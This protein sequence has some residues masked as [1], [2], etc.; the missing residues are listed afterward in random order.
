MAHRSARCAVFPGVLG[1]A[2]TLRDLPQHGH[3]TGHRL[4]HASPSPMP[5][6]SDDVY[7]ERIQRPVARSPLGQHERMDQE[8]GR[9]VEERCIA[10]MSQSEFVLAIQASVGS[11]V[12]TTTP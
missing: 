1:H 11:S 2:R 10:S 9:G 4:V 5:L 6:E 3:F 8:T 12:T 7:G